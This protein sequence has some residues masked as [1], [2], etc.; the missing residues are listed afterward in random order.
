[1][2]SVLVGDG[3][4]MVCKVKGVKFSQKAILK[5][6]LA[7]IFVFNWIYYVIFVYKVYEMEYCI[8]C[9]LLM[10]F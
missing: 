8:C 9:Q 10:V 1:M 3:G 4:L 5:D 7:G 6:L 2:R